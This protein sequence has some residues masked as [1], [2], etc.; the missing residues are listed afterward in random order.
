MNVGEMMW[1]VMLAVP[2]YLIQA[3]QQNPGQ[4]IAIGATIAVLAFVALAARRLAVRR[5]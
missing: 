5:G 2:G 4:W 3:V 1:Q